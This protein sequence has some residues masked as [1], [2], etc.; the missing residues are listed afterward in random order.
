LYVLA[1]FVL[2]EI[3]EQDEG[4]DD[5]CDIWALGVMMYEMV[6]GTTPFYGPSS[7][8]TFTNVLNYALDVFPL[9]LKAQNAVSLNVYSHECNALI[10][11]MLSPAPKNRP[12]LDLIFGGK[13]FAGF[14]WLGLSSQRMKPPAKP[15]VKKKT[16]SRLQ[17]F[18]DNSYDPELDTNEIDVSGFSQDF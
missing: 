18:L 11:A 17:E 15:A 2:Q 9:V 12:S 6:F 3:I 13:Y 4:Y 7:L 10:R 1:N 5:K 8:E 16:T 14:N